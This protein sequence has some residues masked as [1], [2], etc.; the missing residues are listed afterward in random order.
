MESQLS[1]SLKAI[2]LKIAIELKKL[3]WKPD[4]TANEIDVFQGHLGMFKNYFWEGNEDTPDVSVDIIMDM[5]FEQ[6]GQN[7]VHF[8]VYKTDYSLWVDG[9]GGSDRIDNG[10]IDIPF[11]EQDVNNVAKFIEVAR[12]LNDQIIQKAEEVAYEYSQES[13]RR[14]QDYRDQKG[15]QEPEDNY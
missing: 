4:T 10:N 15:W 7:N 5:H 6:N 2:L 13:S 14:Y 12:K 9:V 11:T 8:L 3:R 1:E